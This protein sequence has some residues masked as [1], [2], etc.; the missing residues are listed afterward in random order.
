M[1][2]KIGGGNYWLVQDLLRG[3]EKLSDRRSNFKHEAWK[4]MRACTECALQMSVFTGNI[5]ERL[6]VWIGDARAI[7]RIVNTAV[8]VTALPSKV[9]KSVLFGVAWLGGRG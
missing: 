9:V 6:R 3:N 2:R 7:C 8:A 1:A 4:C 5:S